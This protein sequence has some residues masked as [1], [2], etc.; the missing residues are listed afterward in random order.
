M[1][2]AFVSEYKRRETKALVGIGKTYV[3]T[4]S[5]RKRRTSFQFSTF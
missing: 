2:L 3:R 5:F 4:L 1:R